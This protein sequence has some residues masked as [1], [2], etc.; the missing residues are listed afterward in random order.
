MRDG[1]DIG[2]QQFH[3]HHVRVFLGDVDFAH[4]NFAFQPEI[5]GGGGQRH[6]VLT[7]AGLGNQA[8]FAQVFRQQPFAHA[9]IELVRAGVVEVFAFQ[10]DAP[11]KLVGERFAEIHR[12][13]A[14]LK[15]FANLAQLGDEV[16]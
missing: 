11:A 3:A 9:V 10:I 14:P 2:A 16:V 13:G 1:H 8:F 7:G 4:V 15:V 12:R 5:G 6:A